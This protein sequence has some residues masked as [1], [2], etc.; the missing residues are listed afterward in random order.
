VDGLDR[1]WQW[2]GDTRSGDCFDLLRILK[3]KNK[4]EIREGANAVFIANMH[5]SP[6]AERIRRAS[7]LLVWQSGFDLYDAAGHR[8]ATS[9][10]VLNGG[11]LDNG[12]VSTMDRFSMVGSQLSIYAAADLFVRI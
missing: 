11:R 9:T 12:R 1:R 3:E 8:M 10:A 6:C 7:A 4:S 2:F 5:P